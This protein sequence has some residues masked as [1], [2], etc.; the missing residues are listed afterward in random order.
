MSEEKRFVAFFLSSVMRRTFIRDSAA[1]SENKLVGRCGA[2]RACNNEVVPFEI[3]SMFVVGTF[4]NR[5]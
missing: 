3:D 1:V 5:S 4:L 2:I